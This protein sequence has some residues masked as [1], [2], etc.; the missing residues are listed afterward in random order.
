MGRLSLDLGFTLV[1]NNIK[2]TGK[3]KRNV[4]NFN[5]REP[6]PTYFRFFMLKFLPVVSFIIRNDIKILYAMKREK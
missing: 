6:C 2:S 5:V 4:K 3:F 1:S